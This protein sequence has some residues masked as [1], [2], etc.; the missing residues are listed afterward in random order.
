MGCECNIQY[1]ENGIEPYSF[2][3][4]GITFVNDLDMENIDNNAI[5]IFYYNI[6]DTFQENFEVTQF[7]DWYVGVPKGTLQ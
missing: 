1:K 3:S 4:D 6:V 2:T 5:Y 7:I